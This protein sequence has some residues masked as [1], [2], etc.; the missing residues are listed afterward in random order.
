[1]AVPHVV[2]RLL[3]RQKNIGYVTHAATCSQ[4]KTWR[5]ILHASQVRVGTTVRVVIEE[6]NTYIP[7]EIAKWAAQ[8]PLAKVVSIEGTAVVLEADIAGTDIK[9]VYCSAE[10]LQLARAVC[11]W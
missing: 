11:P 5:T 4:S 8:K 9:T 6:P 7:N 10:Y 2:A 3:V 1:M